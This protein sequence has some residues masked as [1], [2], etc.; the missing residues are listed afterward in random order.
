MSSLM[1]TCTNLVSR[2]QNSTLFCCEAF[3]KDL[4]ISILCS[5]GR[6]PAI[7]LNPRQVLYLFHRLL[8]CISGCWLMHV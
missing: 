5:S 4:Q 2:Q 8:L 6:S 3:H 1:R 7:C